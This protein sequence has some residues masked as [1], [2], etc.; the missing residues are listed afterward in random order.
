[1]EL[2]KKYII[3][4]DETIVHNGHTLYRIQALKDFSDVKKGHKGGW[5]SGYHNLSHF[6]DCWISD[7]AKVYEGAFVFDNARISDYAEIYGYAQVYNEAKV[8]Y[9]AKVYG[10]SNVYNFAKIYGHAKIY[11][12]V[13]IYEHCHIHDYVEIYGKVVICGHSCVNDYAKISGDV[14]INGNTVIC[15]DAIIEDILDYT[16]FKNNWSSGRYFT[17]TKSNKMWKVG[18]FYGTGEELIKRAYS[19]SKFSG[20]MYESCVNLVKLQEEILEEVR[21]NPF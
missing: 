8:W 15:G 14:V 19:D 21:K 20:K 1:M 18:C 10:D 9:H 3:L 7:D 4:E 2:D 11:D 12:F 17:Y 5:V 6:G 13:Q 16:V